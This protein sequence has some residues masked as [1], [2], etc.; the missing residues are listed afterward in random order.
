M[1]GGLIANATLS[2]PGGGA[3]LR[4]ALRLRLSLLTWLGILLLLLR[5]GQLALRLLRL[6]R[7][8]DSDLLVAGC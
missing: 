3:D 6:L 7:S 1:W 2:K 8:H 4:K 5:V